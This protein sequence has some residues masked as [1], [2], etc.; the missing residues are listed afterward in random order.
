MN[1]G[2]RPSSEAITG[3]SAATRHSS[4][5]DSLFMKDAVMYRKFSHKD[6]T[7]TY[8]QFVVP[9]SLRSEVLY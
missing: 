3:L 8:H 6:G 5:W 1:T 2:L 9:I 7:A 4:Q